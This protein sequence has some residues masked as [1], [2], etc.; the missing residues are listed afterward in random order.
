MLPVASPT[1]LPMEIPDSW[2]YQRMEGHSWHPRT[3]WSGLPNQILSDWASSGLSLEVSPFSSHWPTI[4][5]GGTFLAKAY[6]GNYLKYSADGVDWQSTSLPVPPDFSIVQA[7]FVNNNF[8]I[9]GNAHGDIYYSPNAKPNSWQLNNNLT[10]TFPNITQCLSIAQGENGQI[11]VTVTGNQFSALLTSYGGLYPWNVSYYV[12]QPYSASQ[13]SSLGNNSVY[14]LSARNNSEQAIMVSLDRGATWKKASTSVAGMPQQGVHGV[15]FVLGDDGFL[16]YTTDGIQWQT[17]D[18]VQPAQFY[19]L[20]QG[21]T[22]FFY[23]MLQT[24]P[25]MN[26]QVVLSTK[27]GIYGNSG[28]SWRC[29]VLHGRLTL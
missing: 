25:V 19:W 8:M 10:R 9:V 4:T 23:S 14:F 21:L 22:S 26:S 27:T 13:V 20:L 17:H 6:A 11:L 3:E 29:G 2:S 1:R 15:S 16:Q 12:S 24:G 18:E 5:T 7:A 28:D